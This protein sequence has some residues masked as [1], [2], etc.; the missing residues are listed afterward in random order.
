MLI[1]RI[2]RAIAIAYNWRKKVWW[3]S[4]SHCQINSHLAFCKSFIKQ[5]KQNIY[6]TKLQSTS[7]HKP[8]LFP[9]SVS[10]EAT[11]TIRLQSKTK[12]WA[13]PRR[14]SLVTPWFYS[15]HQKKVGF[16]ISEMWLRLEI[17]F[18]GPHTLLDPNCF[19]PYFLHVTLF[20]FFYNVPVAPNSCT[21]YDGCFNWLTSGFLIV[22]LKNE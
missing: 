19:Y 17:W 2:H 1:S 20:L 11:S 8:L 12:E 13:Q 4:T 9:F 6:L 22:L 3:M 15:F 14:K 5:L 7:T 10:S 16:I 18:N 21:A